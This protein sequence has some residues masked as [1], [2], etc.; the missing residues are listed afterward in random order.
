MR[1]AELPH[2]VSLHIGRRRFLAVHD[3][4]SQRA[5]GRCRL[6]PNNDEGAIEATGDEIW[7]ESVQYLADCISDSIPRPFTLRVGGWPENQD[8]LP[9]IMRVLAADRGPG[10]CR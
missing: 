10:K 8:Q 7:E 6:K 5:E 3:R 1:V 2:D 4:L 9:Q